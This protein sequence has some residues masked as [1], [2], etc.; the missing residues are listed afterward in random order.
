MNKKLRR[1]NFPTYMVGIF[2]LGNCY[3]YFRNR[4]GATVLNEDTNLGKFIAKRRKFMRLTQ[5]ELAQR[6]G[7][8][9]SA[10]AKWETDGG[11][12]ERDNLRKLSEVLNVSVDDLHRIIN[13]DDKGNFELSVNITTDVI[14]T[15]ESYG[16][17]V[18]RPDE[19]RRIRNEKDN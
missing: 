17:K 15:L 4:K 7:V 9:K 2:L 5:E 8:S 18:I 10:I 1:V 13:R 6:I 16:Y 19:Q 12:P 14:A 11:L 3:D